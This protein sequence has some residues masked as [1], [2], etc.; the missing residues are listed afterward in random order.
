[1]KLLPVLIT[2]ALVSS[3]ALAR[4]ICTASQEC[5]PSPE[6]WS[7]FNASISGRLIAPRPPAWPCHDPNYDEGAC[8]VARAN[9][10]DPFWRSNQTGAMQD[11]VWE[12][13]G[14]RINTP[15]NMTCE[16]GFVPT[17]LVA[18]KDGSDVSKAIVFA[19][20]Y[21]LKLVVK[22]TGHDLYVDDLLIRST[23]ADLT[24]L[25]ESLGRSS[26]AGSFSIWTHQLKGINFA[27][28]FVPIGCSQSVVGVP[29][30]TL[31]AAEQWRDV[32][33][34]VDERNMTIVGG[35]SKTVGA[36]GG[37]VQGGGHSPLGALYGM[38]VDNV[39]QFTV[40]KP[41]GE[42]VKANACQNKDLFW[43]LRGGGGGT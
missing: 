18:A 40:V 34:A 23:R 15:R 38:A 24:V 36:A 11:P 37:Y 28:S 21:R 10:D 8:G 16:Q 29:A 1:M 22:N 42:V 2:P 30:V 5:W 33:Q 35:A 14:C 27:D 3:A 7:S 13:S 41:D 6:V 20:K 31:G 39:L 12:S 25:N 17:Y 32:Y 26:G 19:G 4:N 43:A 9:W